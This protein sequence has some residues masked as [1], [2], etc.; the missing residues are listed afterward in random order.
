MFAEFNHFI[1]WFCSLKKC[2]FP[3]QRLIVVKWRR[4]VSWFTSTI[5]NYDNISRN[6]RACEHQKWYIKLILAGLVSNLCINYIFSEIFH[7]SCFSTKRS[8][9][10]LGWKC[11]CITVNTRDSEHIFINKERLP[12]PIVN[13]FTSPNEIVKQYILKYILTP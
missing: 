2:Y 7:I 11:R 1:W 5:T 3:I 8:C 4:P 12:T 13:T 9:L 6:L 10:K